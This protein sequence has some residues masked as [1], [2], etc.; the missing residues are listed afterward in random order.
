MVGT[1]HRFCFA[2]FRTEWLR[3]KQ[4]MKTAGRENPNRWVTVPSTRSPH[5]AVAQEP[6]SLDNAAQLCSRR[7]EDDSNALFDNPDRK[8]FFHFALADKFYSTAVSLN[9]PTLATRASLFR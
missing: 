1:D 2:G 6:I 8:S 7:T 3:R 4:P 5:G 9:E